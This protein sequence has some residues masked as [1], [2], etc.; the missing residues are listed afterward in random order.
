MASAVCKGGATR[1]FD[2]VPSRAIR[3]ARVSCKAVIAPTAPDRVRYSRW[4]YRTA[5]AR[6]NFPNNSAGLRAVRTLVRGSRVRS[7]CVFGGLALGTGNATSPRGGKGQLR[8]QELART[9]C[10]GERHGRDVAGRVR[11]EPCR[12]NWANAL[13]WR[14]A[15]SALQF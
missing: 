15:S 4:E 13:R 10:I 14:L 5:P 2:A 8:R 6:K 1:H 11:N 3:L 9:N 7:Q 12:H